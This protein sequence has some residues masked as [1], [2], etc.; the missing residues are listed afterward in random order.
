VE[1]LQPLAVGHVALAP[2]DV[3]YVAGVDW[4]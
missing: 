4:T 1:F 3:V 2:A